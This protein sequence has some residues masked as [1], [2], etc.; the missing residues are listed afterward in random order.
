MANDDS[1]GSPPT[2]QVQNSLQG[3]AIG[4]VED[5]ATLAVHAADCNWCYHQ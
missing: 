3:E 5:D 2:W 4:R 1:M